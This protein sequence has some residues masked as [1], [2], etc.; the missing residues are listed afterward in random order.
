MYLSRITIQNFRL[1]KTVE[2]PLNPGLNLIVGENDSGKTAVLDAIR[3]LLGTRDYERL[4]ITLDD[5]YVG[6]DGREKTLRIGADF[7]DFSDEEASVFLEWLQII[8]T[9]PSSTP[10]FILH[11]RLEAIR[12]DHSELTNRF[13]TDVSWSITAGSSLTGTGMESEAKELLRVTYLKPLRDAEQELAP[14]RGSRL[15][16]I[17]YSHPEI[18]A[19]ENGGDDSVLQIIQDANR[20]VKEH[21][22]IAQQITD[23]NDQYLGNFTLGENS[24]HA[25]VNIANP[26][27]KAILERLEL[28]ITDGNL[29][30][31]TKHGLGLNNLLFMATE[32]LLLQSAHSPALPL[33]L[34]EEPEAHLHPQFQLRLMKF[35]EGQATR[36]GERQ[37]Q[38]IMTSHSPN[39]ASKAPLESVVMMKNGQA[40]PLGP[41]YTQLEK[42]DYKFL[43]RFL[44]V[45][46]ANLFFA[47]G[48][49]IVEGDAEQLLL[50]CLA[51]LIGRPLDKFGVSIVKVGHVGLFR[52]ARIFQ[53]RVG[54]PINIRVSC[55][56]DLDI[57]PDEAQFYLSPKRRTK[58]HFT[59]EDIA[60]IQESKRGRSEGGP[61]KTFV[62]PHWTL[63]YDLAVSDTEIARLMHQAIQ[64]GMVSKGRPGG[65]TDTERTQIIDVA[66]DC[67]NDWILSRASNEEICVRVYQPLYEDRA[68]KVETA[69]F[70]VELL[71]K[72]RSALGDSSIRS[73]IPEY[74]VQ[75]I[76]FST[77]AV[78]EQE[79]RDAESI[80]DL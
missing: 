11:I 79:Q 66:N 23:L 34:I 5:F 64:L 17:L 37:V 39:L 24:L 8:H 45:T 56:T 40:F 30:E 62:S 72:N 74:L 68:S 43:E 33:V 46:K 71:L 16:Q 52:Y 54:E 15:S 75:A 35:L 58:S 80:F 78:I 6:S 51:E 65:F 32:L 38:V 4:R 27:L 60:A 18:R 48:V 28:A 42:S 3:L 77:G 26:N 41:K 49:M 29:D 55:L 25:A 50:P 10:K 22:L 1:I 20:R 36:T 21:P 69:Q 70:F 59:A 12:K 61:V 63:E 76:D 73:R 31:L 53:R 47:R 13:D 44:D 2:I 19:Q 7:E 9:H 57:P 67:F 14:R